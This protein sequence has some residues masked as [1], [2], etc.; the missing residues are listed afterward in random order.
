MQN[1]QSSDDQGEIYVQ[2]LQEAVNSKPGK[3]MRR[4]EEVALVFRDWTI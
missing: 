2:Y 4:L 1:V 3:H